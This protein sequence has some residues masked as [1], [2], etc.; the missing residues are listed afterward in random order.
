MHKDIF[1]N[2]YIIIPYGELSFSTSRA[3]GPGGQHVNKTNSRITLRWNIQ[4]TS[5][6]TDKEK[7][8]IFTKLANHLTQDG[9]IIIHNSQT[10]SQYENKK[11]AMNNLS[12]LISKSLKP[13][14]KRKKTDIPKAK[15]ESRLQ[16][17]SLHSK[18]KKMRKKVSLN[19]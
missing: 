9:E 8:L 2:N 5:V 19:D 6:L 10:S 16:S 4:A 15:K 12:L 13:E 14:K 1:I 17:K 7:E 3:S 18:L 11:R